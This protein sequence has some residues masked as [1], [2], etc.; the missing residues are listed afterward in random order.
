MKRPAYSKL[1][2]EKMTAEEI[3]AVA[4]P[5]IRADALKATNRFFDVKMKRRPDESAGEFLQRGREATKAN[6]SEYPRLLRDNLEKKIFN[7][8]DNQSQAKADKMF[9]GMKMT[10]EEKATLEAHQEARARRD[11]MSDREGGRNFTAGPVPSV[12]EWDGAPAKAKPSNPTRPTPPARR[13]QG[14]GKK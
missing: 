12:A 13:P 7:S 9:A 6:K 3:T 11:A 2:L 4:S 8:P 5:Q 1:E 10:A 14:R